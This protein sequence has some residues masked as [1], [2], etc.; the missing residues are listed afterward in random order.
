M[1][2]IPPVVTLAIT[3]QVFACI[4]YVLRGGNPFDRGP[5]CQLTASFRRRF[6]SSDGP[7]RCNEA[8]RRQKMKSRIGMWMTAAYVCASVSMLIVTMAAPANAQQR[9]VYRNVSP[10]WTGSNHMSQPSGSLPQTSNAN[11]ETNNN[12]ARYDVVPIGVLPGKTTS[13]LTV[14]RAVN[15]REH[16]VGYSYLYSG[17]LFLTGQG[18]LWQ[19]GQLQALPLL[20]GWPGAFAFG[21]NESV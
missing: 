19:D 17:N 11:V 3:P 10:P 4:L 5:A 7:N 15:N 12:N 13:F 16:V 20:Q 18:F 1:H 8:M 21:I 6:R 9:D 14:V 2:G